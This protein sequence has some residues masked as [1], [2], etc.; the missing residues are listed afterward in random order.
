MNPDNL[1]CVG[2]RNLHYCISRIYALAVD[3]HYLVER[4]SGSRKLFAAAVSLQLFRYF[5]TRVYMS[6]REVYLEMR[7]ESKY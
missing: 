3:S 6:L 7:Y 4:V 1:A 2:A 5:T